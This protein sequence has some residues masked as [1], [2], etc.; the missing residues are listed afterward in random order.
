MHLIITAALSAIVL[1]GLYLFTYNLAKK[2]ALA[3]MGL[4]AV[5]LIPIV[6]ALYFLSPRGEYVLAQISRALHKLRHGKARP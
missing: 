2:S 5:S 1:Q 4:Y 6:I 3:N